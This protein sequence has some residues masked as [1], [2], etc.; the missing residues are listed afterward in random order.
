[1]KKMLNESTIRGFFK[2]ANLGEDQAEKF[3]KKRKSLKE[4]L[5]EM[6]MGDED[7][8]GMDDEA[9]APDMEMGGEEPPMDDMEMGDED[10]LYQLL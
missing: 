9:P 10:I 8:M 7:E 6:E 3:L 5:D 1:M 2:L 4:N